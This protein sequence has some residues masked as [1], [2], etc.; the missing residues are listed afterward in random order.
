M[1]SH[2]FNRIAAAWLLAAASMSA[3]ASLIG[4]SVTVNNQEAPALNGTFVV[5][6][7][8]EQSHC[9][10]FV[11][12]CLLGIDTD[13]GADTID[14]HMYNLLPPPNS[15]PSAANVVTLTFSGA[16]LADVSV[17]SSTF[18]A[19]NFLV[20]ILADNVLRWTHDAWLW[21]AQSD[22]RLV[23]GVKTVPEPGTISLFGAGALLL[24]LLRLR[25]AA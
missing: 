18:P 14:V 9:F 13:F 23:V 8:V 5:G 24:G 2:R 3:Q 16:V 20:S 22:Y 6:A 17:L 4:S 7:G 11:G 25:R 10:V 21:E 1:W 15:F 19:P 12:A